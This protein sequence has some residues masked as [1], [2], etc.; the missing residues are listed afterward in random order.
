MRKTAV[1]ALLALFLVPTIGA[2]AQ[3]AVVTGEVVYKNARPAVNCTVL[4]GGKFAFVDVRGRFRIFNV[5]FGTYTLQVKRQGQKL[6]EM[7]ITINQPQFVVPRI[8]I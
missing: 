7:R 3:T 6:K 8:V 2:F 4:L 5:P 1:V